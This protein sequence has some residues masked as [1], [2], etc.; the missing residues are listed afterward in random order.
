MSSDEQARQLRGFTIVL[1]ILTLFL[2]GLTVELII[3]AH[4]RLAGRL[5]MRHGVDGQPR[6]VRGTHR[7]SRP[8]AGAP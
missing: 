8:T 4:L 3:R 6:S 7:P 5:V 1:V 2:V